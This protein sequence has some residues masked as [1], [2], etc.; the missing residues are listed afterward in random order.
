MHYISF[1]KMRMYRREEMIVALI[2]SRLFPFPQ[3]LLNDRC[4]L[5][6]ERFDISLIEGVHERIGGPRR[7]YP[8]QQK[9]EKTLHGNSKVTAAAG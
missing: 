4:T 5:W 1:V 8:D 3:W 2:T 7:H 6:F 9:R